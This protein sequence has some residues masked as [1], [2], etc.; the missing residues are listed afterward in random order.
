[1]AAGGISHLPEF[2]EKPSHSKE[3]QDNPRKKE[4][5]P[6]EEGLDSLG[7]LRP[8]RDF[9]MGYGGNFQKA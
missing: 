8:I 9:S 1:L 4:A 7:F 6:M 5:N 3:L 2:Q